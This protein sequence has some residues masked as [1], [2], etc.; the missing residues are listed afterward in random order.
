MW[1]NKS[2]ESSQNQWGILFS[3]RVISQRRY[4]L[5]YDLLVKYRYKLLRAAL[6]C[7]SVPE[8]DATARCWSVFSYHKTKWVLGKKGGGWGMNEINYVFIIQYLHETG[9][10]WRADG[11][12]TWYKSFYLHINAQM[13][14]PSLSGCLVL[15]FSSNKVNCRHHFWS[16]APSATWQC[17]TVLM[18][19]H[20]WQPGGIICWVLA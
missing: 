10:S 20:D 17:F 15:S 12:I 14:P 1:A 5:Y 8:E 18:T 16:K 6:V 3:V 19:C 2:F 13:V 4:K 11:N 7:C 9:C